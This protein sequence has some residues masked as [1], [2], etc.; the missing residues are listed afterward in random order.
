MIIYSTYWR[1]NVGIGVVPYGSYFCDRTQLLQI[2]GIISDFSNLLCW[3]PQCSVLGL[4]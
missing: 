4:M 3:V 1:D 2:D